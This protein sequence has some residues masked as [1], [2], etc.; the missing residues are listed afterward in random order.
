[1]QTG[2]IRSAY[3]T[4]AT[5]R[6]TKQRPLS[7][8]K[9]PSAFRANCRLFMS[10]R[11]RCP[12]TATDNGDNSSGLEAELSKW[13]HRPKE[14]Q[15]MPPTLSG[16][17]VGRLRT[18]LRAVRVR[19]GKSDALEIEQPPVLGALKLL[20]QGLKLRIGDP[21]LRRARPPDGESRAA[22]ML[23]RGRDE[24]HAN[25]PDL[26]LHCQDPTDDALAQGIDGKEFLFPS[27]FVSIVTAQCAASH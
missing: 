6:G 24:R 13:H 22:A 2:R 21:V 26:A 15:R 20:D 19:A 16:R 9:P 11:P 5:W 12:P 4:S 1:M 23:A 25:A 8:R 3:G 10:S 17:L 7:T 27:L 14:S 18:R